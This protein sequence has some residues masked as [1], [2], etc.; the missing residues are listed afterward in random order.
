[1]RA[2]SSRHAYVEVGALTPATI[3]VVNQAPAGI[4]VC[5]A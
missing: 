1:M 2:L 3:A 5:S 4:R